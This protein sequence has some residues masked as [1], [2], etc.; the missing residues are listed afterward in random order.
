MWHIF[1]LE[2]TTL[3]ILLSAYEVYYELLLEAQNDSESV[4]GERRAQIASVAWQCLDAMFQIR[5]WLTLE[6]AMLRQQIASVGDVTDILQLL[7]K[8]KVSVKAVGSF[9]SSITGE[10]S[11]AWS[12]RAPHLFFVSRKSILWRKLKLTWK[13]ADFTVN[14]NCCRLLQMI[15]E[16]LVWQS[17][18]ICQIQSYWYASDTRTLFFSRSL[19]AMGHILALAQSVG[20][21]LQSTVYLAA[22][23]THRVPSSRLIPLAGF[24]ISFYGAQIHCSPHRKRNAGGANCFWMTALA[25]AHLSNYSLTRRRRRRRCSSGQRLTFH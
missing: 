10:I 13:S 8:Q 20:R 16:A 24:S 18:A 1:I 6:E 11:H 19:G 12:E 2:S 25:R 9:F 22:R 23:D 15:M 4:D 3:P 5:D 21:A 17:V 14:Y 7:D